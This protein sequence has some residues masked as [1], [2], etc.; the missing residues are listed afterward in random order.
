MRPH[1][2]R[3][4]TFAITALGVSA[5]QTVPYEGQA[6][7]VSLKPKAL[8][9]IS[10][11]TDSRNEDRAKADELMMRNCSPYL[12]EVTSEGEVAVGTKVDSKEKTTER[13]SSERKVAS[14][15][16]IPV[17]TGEAGGTDGTSS[18]T[19]TQLKEW[20]ISYKCKKADSKSL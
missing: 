2:L 4:L 20:H 18:S 19:T 11:P 9:V 16:G 8:G 6:R 10:I 13:A 7:N 12:P 5:C 1:S 14:L 15:F 3:I 17:T